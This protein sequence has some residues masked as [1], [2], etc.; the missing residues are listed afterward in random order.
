M[1][2][3][4][5]A[6]FVRPPTRGK[7]K[8]RLE[9][10]FGTSGAAE[11]YSAFVEDELRLCTRIRDAGHI[12]LALWT[13]ELGGPGVAA[14]SET[15]GVAPQLQPAGDLGERLGVAFDE[16][17]RHYERVVVIGSDMPTL[18]FSLVVAAFDAL[19]AADITLAPANDGGYTLIG[20]TGPRRPSF[21]GVRWS[22]P[23]AFVDTVRANRTREVAVLPPWYDVDDENDLD[24]L[25]AHLSV[26]PSAAP[27]TRRCLSRLSELRRLRD[28]A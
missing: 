27:A 22:T 3:A 21:D 5:L 8:T 6:I 24:V 14:W 11:L 23:T 17:L 12:D 15:L 18:P 13:T 9:P 4:Q 19:D 1:G 28:T 26:R 25:R 10:I 7:V 20:A 16:G 2:L